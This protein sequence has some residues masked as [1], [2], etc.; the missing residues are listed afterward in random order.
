MSET[1]ALKAEARNQVGTK[2]SVKLRREGKLPAIV[3][4]H[5]QEPVAIALD[6]HNFVEMLHHGHRLFEVKLDGASQTML[7]KDLQYD[8]LGKDIIH[9][10]LVRV[11]LTETVKI[12]VPIEL[13]GSAKGTHEGGIVDEHLDHLEIECKVSDIPEVIPVWIK[14]LGIGDTI[15]AGSVEL[16]EGMK[17]VTPPET[18]VLT[19]HLVAAAKST[20][21]LEEEMPAAPEVITEKVE[22]E[23][24]GE[25]G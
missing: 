18:L 19:C 7:V 20:E 15:H 4:G 8:H 5:G 25:S 21:E 16:E 14:D 10:D 11:D 24:Q 12:T 3:Y 22:P 13:K 2:Y 6:F 23:G 17:L 9:A 1:I